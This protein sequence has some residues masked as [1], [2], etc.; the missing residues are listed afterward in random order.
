MT[1]Q[2]TFDVYSGSSK[3]EYGIIYVW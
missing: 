3:V 1:S 2:V